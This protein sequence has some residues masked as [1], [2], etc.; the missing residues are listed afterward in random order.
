MSDLKPTP[1]V[2]LPDE[3][4]RR[5]IRERKH[6]FGFTYFGASDRMLPCDPDGGAG[7][8]GVWLHE[9]DVMAL[10]SHF[11]ERLAKLEELRG[12]IRSMAVD[13]HGRDWCLVAT[14]YVDIA[15]VEQLLEE[16]KGEHP[17]ISQAT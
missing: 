13:Q 3:E 2:D 15:R 9:G 17:S 7:H 4:I 11:D 8:D 5:L 12:L 14:D 6:A 16:L 10:I 1:F